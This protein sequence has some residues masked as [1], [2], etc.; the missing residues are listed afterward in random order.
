MQKESGYVADHGG[1]VR[2]LGLRGRLIALALIGLVPMLAFAGVLLAQ[3]ADAARD[4]LQARVRDTA[5][6][7]ALIVDQEIQRAQ[8]LLIALA[9][10]P[11]LDSDDLAGFHRQAALSTPDRFRWIIL[12]DRERNQVVNTLKPFGT[13][14]PKGMPAPGVEE[15]L[16]TG[17]PAVTD[18]I[19]GALAGRPIVATGVPVLRNDKV[20]AVLSVTV[21]VEALS[22]LLAAQ[23][24]PEGWT[25][26]LIDRGGRIIARNRAA[27]TYVGKRPVPALVEAIR[28][29]PRGSLEIPTLEGTLTYAAFARAAASGWSVAVGAPQAALESPLRRTLVTL[30]SGGGVLL[31]LTVLLAMATARRIA[32]PVHRLVAAAHAVGRGEVPAVAPTGI[33][34]ADEVGRA[35]ANAAVLLRQRAEARDDAIAASEQAHRRTLDVLESIGD[36]FFALDAKWRFSYANRRAL[37]LWGKPREAIIGHRILDVFPELVGSVPHEAYLA[38]AADRRIRHL[39]VESPVFHRWLS[40]NIYPAADGGLT[41]YFRDITRRKAAEQRQRLL[42]DELNHRVKNTLATVQSIAMQTSRNAESPAEFFDTFKA[43]LHALAR[44]HDVLTKRAWEGVTLHEIVREALAP[45][46]AGDGS[47]TRIAF[48]GPRITVAPNIAVTLSMA[49]H[50]LATN[51]AKY[52]ALSAPSGQA[53]LGWRLV[54]D[55]GLPAVE[56]EWREAGGPPVRPPDRK[57]FGSRL[58][59]RGLPA[60]F[61]GEVDLAFPPDG[62]RCR[63]RLPLSEK[64]K[65]S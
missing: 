60:E 48:D 58:L 8:S 11:Q 18:L 23:P 43:R 31:A 61:D 4:S 40:V 20:T 28:A 44:A 21:S 2:R 55:D 46:M 41:V 53:T 22:A 34:E 59:E 7:V 24:I 35:L 51:A 17:R 12:F 49:L 15:V 1:W 30:V 64:V 57:G 50:E 13:P 9:A 36:A 3:F 10:S 27:E 6:T 54:E 14:L 37:E 38:V 33:A 62:A 29:A 47:R 26:A 16:R 25:V 39:D 19:T 45:F 5:S 63:I 56:I 65:A 42:L 52:G 32:A